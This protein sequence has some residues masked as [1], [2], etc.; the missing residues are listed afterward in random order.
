[1]IFGVLTLVLAAPVSPAS[2]APIQP[3][4]IPGWLSGHPAPDPLQASLETSYN[5]HIDSWKAAGADGCPGVQGALAALAAAKHETA[6]SWSA[7][8]GAYEALGSAH[9][10]ALGLIATRLT[11]LSANLALFSAQLQ[12]AFGQLTVAQTA[13]VS[14]ASLATAFSSAAS[15][16]YQGVIDGNQDVVSNGINAFNVAANLLHGDAANAA[17]VFGRSLSI[18][19]TMIDILKDIKQAEDDNGAALSAFTTAGDLYSRSLN[20]IEKA[21][22]QLNTSYKS[23]TCAHKHQGRHGCPYKNL[24]HIVVAPRS[25]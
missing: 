6:T 8:E 11:A 12:V 10:A 9:A 19:T 14:Y 22:T 15:T 18:V 17:N 3:P 23:C 13:A 7:L 2:A 20:N 16:I 24:A 21:I 25:S 1:M 4:A 5:A